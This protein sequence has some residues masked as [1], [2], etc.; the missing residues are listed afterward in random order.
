[1]SAPDIWVRFCI[2]VLYPHFVIINPSANNQ[3]EPRRCIWWMGVKT[4]S[5]WYRERVKSYRKIRTGGPARGSIQIVNSSLL[6]MSASAKTIIPISFLFDFI[7]SRGLHHGFRTLCRYKLLELVSKCFF[8]IVFQRHRGV[9][10]RG[11]GNLS[12]TIL[13]EK[14][15]TYPATTSFRWWNL[16]MRRFFL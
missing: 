2:R 4:G 16:L 3:T 8:S 15:E 11:N 10:R 1:M 14:D 9:P 5:M 13:R 6:N 12:S 7:C